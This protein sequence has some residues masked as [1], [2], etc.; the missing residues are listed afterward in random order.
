MKIRYLVALAAAV[1]LIGAPAASAD[2]K[3]D[4]QAAVY[5]TV[6]G[7]EAVYKTVTVVDSPPVPAIYEDVKIIDVEY[8]PY[9]PPTEEVSHYEEYVI[10]PGEEAYDETVVDKEPYDETVIDVPAKPGQHYSLKG[11]SDIGKDEVPVWP[12]DYWQANTEQEPHDN[13]AG[14]PVTWLDVEGSGLHY[15]SHGSQGNRD[16]FYYEAPVAEVSHV[17]HHEAE[18]HIVHHDAVPPV[19]GTTKVIDVYASPGQPEVKE[20]SHIETILLSPY[21]PGHNHT[22]K[23]LVSAATPDQKVLVAAAIPASNTCTSTNKRLA[24][25][26]GEWIPLAGGLGLLLIL[27]GGVIAAAARKRN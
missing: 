16:W 21:V 26:G 22:R 13:G 23:V 14:N 9:L 6:P 10:V 25:T 7:D 27:A 8:Q 1:T 4:A 3:T 24:Q 18:T 17:V 15:A 5:A 11:Y 12:A 20:E 2:C 19:M